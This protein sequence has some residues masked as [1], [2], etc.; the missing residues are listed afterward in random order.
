MD[1]IVDQN[2]WEWVKVDISRSERNIAEKLSTL[3]CLINVQTKIN[4]QGVNKIGI[5]KRTG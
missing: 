1:V 3:G 5:N 2:G 4:V